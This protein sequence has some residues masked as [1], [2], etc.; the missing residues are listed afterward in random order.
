VGIARLVG[1]S[2]VPL[3]AEGLDGVETPVE[4]GDL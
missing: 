3:E 1:G 4:V 2:I